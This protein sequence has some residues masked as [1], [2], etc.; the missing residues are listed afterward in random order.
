VNHRLRRNAR[1]IA[2]S[3][4]LVLCAG[5]AYVLHSAGSAHAQPT[6]TARRVH[7]I[8]PVLASA[9][10]RHAALVATRAGAS[11][12]R[13][14]AGARV[15]SATLL[16]RRRT[17]GLPTSAPSTRTVSGA[18]RKLTGLTPAQVRPRAVCPPATPGHVTC[19]A[20][21]LVLRSS[22]ALVRPRVARYS[23]FGRVR[24]ASTRGVQPA[25]VPAATAPDPGT[26]AYLQQ[27]YDLSYL[28]QYRG[29]GDTL[30]VVD[31]HDDPSAE[32]DLQTYRANYNLPACTTAN[33]C[34]QKVGQDGT[35]SLPAPDPNW[36]Q[37]IALDLDS[38]SAICPSCHILLVEVNSSKFA[39]LQA[40]MATAAAL[41]ANQIAASWFGTSASN[42]GT[43]Q[44]FSGVA[45]VAATGDYG[46]PGA[47][48]D[49]YPAA[50]PGVTAAGGT[51]LAPAAVSGGRGFG[52]SA[53]SWNGLNGGG[54]GCD[55]QF[56]RP[57]YQPAAGCA[58][59]AYADL[60]ADAD[61][62]TGLNIYNQG[63]WSVVGGTS[64][65]APLIAAYYAIT[66]IAGATPQ[67][68][69]GKSGV[70]NDLVDGFSGNCA[71]SISY[72]C[73]AGPG[74]DGPTGV[75]SI[76]GSVITG[77][78]GID[79]PA[80]NSGSGNTYT[81]SVAAHSATIAGG[82]YRNG[83]DTKWWIEYGTDTSYG[84]QT[85]A[86][87]IGAGS[88]PVP[89]TG[90]LSQLAP[91]TTYH[92]R[93]VAQNSL[94]T[95]DG[96]DYTF[97]TPAA[98]TGAPTAA[99]TVLTTSPTP[100]APVGFSAFASTAPSGSSI[101]DYSWTFGDGTKLD[102]G[103]TT[104][105]S[106][107]YAARG[108]YTATLTVKT[109]Q[110]QT[111]SSS[112]TVIVDNAPTAAF[113]PSDTAVPAGS[114]VAFDGSASKAGAGGRLT[115][116]SWGFGDGST[117]D[118]GSGATE[119]HTFTT[120]GTY[121]V[122]LTTTD[123]L[124]VTSTTTQTITVASFTANP[125]IPAPGSPATFTADAPDPSCGTVTG[126]TWDFGDGSD[127]QTTTDPTISYTYATREAYTVSLSYTCSDTPVPSSTA[128]VNVDSPP[129][130]AFTPSATVFVPGTTVSFDAS[131]SSAG[132]TISDYA[133][134]F[135][136]G[137]PVLHTTT[138]AAS[139]TFSTPGTY[140]VTLTITDDMGA[141]STPASAQ[142]TADE[143][144]A[145][146]TVSS[147][148]PAP[149]SPVSFDGSASS[150][151]ASP[152]TDYTWN[153]GDGTGVDAG[154]NSHTTHSFSAAGTY[155]VKL[156]VT[157]QVG[158]TDSI[159]REVVIAPAVSDSSNPPTTT[160]TTPTPTPTPTP[161][162]TT[163]VTPHPLTST[164]PVAKTQA[165][166]SLVA[167]LTGTHRQRL[168]LVLAHGLK[169]GLTL[170][171]RTRASFQITIPLAQTK[172][173]SAARHRPRGNAVLVRG[174]QTLAAGKH[175]I[176]LKLSRAAG[177]RLAAKGPLVLTVRVTLAGTGGAKTLTRTIKVTLTR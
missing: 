81:E 73:N 59:R 103:L 29:A 92:Y 147:S 77:A 143:P 101:S 129:T 90:Y 119:S 46:Y 86:Q 49:N 38:V 155:A 47:G 44:T 57:A 4:A 54:S 157:D 112:Q 141:T 99:F 22:G 164:P 120:P 139:H 80:I 116:Y 171:Q 11:G 131:A 26:P 16:G 172:Q 133:W 152:I 106:H 145:A 71:A 95:T 3:L 63:H 175:T 137:S 50:L 40:G 69:Y 27:A 135:G 62:Q 17:G 170:N 122:S 153:F 55:L 48:M 30:A 94:G 14:A 102:K 167:R 163:P 132:G 124:N 83:L 76:S 162:T 142:V 114:T 34:F 109:Y 111:D 154:A 118:G 78:P 24:R 31:V 13:P 138:P 56:P 66:G 1:L 85:P 12:S 79:G 149:D 134:S 105:A 126:Y 156:T 20:Q 65:A 8:A 43:F 51:T 146:F 39:N 93:L 10:Q 140:T 2:G 100:G 82:I 165:P 61:P 35:S 45:T 108:T 67:W 107:T 5:V 32:Q 6:R 87:D 75:G 136:D 130:A 15:R 144:T 158:Q 169:L 42:P 89:V 33:G 23:T 88:S 84:S 28:S 68:A 21:E 161:T 97:T 166:L 151:P 52:E 41:G 58:G 72:I 177:R 7:A 9:S 150:D 127:P 148:N 37:E 113:T 53:W 115:D 117:A 174:V 60:S 19:A 168:T 121:N 128:T 123:D 159:T 18:L 98:A 91:G 104:S 176:T 160:T 125:A 96:Y 110:G 70:L 25:S 36:E 173:G 74:Y 64:L